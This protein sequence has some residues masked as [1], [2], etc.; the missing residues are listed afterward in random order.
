MAREVLN[1]FEEK[2]N[3]M[4]EFFQE[5]YKIKCH[6]IKQQFEKTKKT[7]NF[8]R[9]FFKQKLKVRIL[10]DSKKANVSKFDDKS[11]D[12]IEKKLF[13]YLLDEGFAYSMDLLERKVQKVINLKKNCKQTLNLQSN[14]SLN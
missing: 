3:K 10:I 14:Y 9:D 8:E 7:V 5:A 12:F 11:I 13:E 1:D 6:K 2:H 4:R